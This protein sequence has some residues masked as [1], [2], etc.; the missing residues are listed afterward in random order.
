MKIILSSIYGEGMNRL[1]AG[2]LPR[3]KKIFRSIK[4]NR[5]R[6]SVCLNL[7]IFFWQKNVTEEQDP[8]LKKQQWRPSFELERGD[9]S[10]PKII[11]PNN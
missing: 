7:G 4:R 9:A 10:H 2:N 3:N 8:P 1:S 5:M 11:G 6:E